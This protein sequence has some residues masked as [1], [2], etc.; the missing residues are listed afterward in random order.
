MR[1]CLYVKA[2][3]GTPQN[4][5]IYNISMGVDSAECKAQTRFMDANRKAEMQNNGKS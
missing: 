2:T 3:T 1:E 5:R 4:M